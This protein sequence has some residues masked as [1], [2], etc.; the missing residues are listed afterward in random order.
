MKRITAEPGLAPKTI[1]VF[2]DASSSGKKR[3]THAGSLA[4]RWG[5]HLVGVNVVVGEVAL[6][7]SM[8]YA[9][10]SQA[11]RQVTAYK[12]RL[13]SDAAAATARVNEHFRALCA[14]LRVSGELRL[15]GQTNSVKEAVRIAFHS[16]LVVVGHPEPNGLS[17]DLSVEKLLLASGTPTLIVPNAWEGESIGTNVLIGWNA[18]REARRAVTDAMVFLVAAK[19][20]TV[21]VIDAHERYQTDKDRGSEIA[22]RLD[23]HGAHVDLERMVSRGFSIPAVLLGYA[24]Q[25]ASDLLVVGAYSRARFKELLLG[26]TTR[27]LLMHT[28][29]PTFMSR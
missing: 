27:T 29:M 7:A 13:A 1:A 26:G 15:I 9:R 5:A 12:R 22:L 10:G 18:T 23:R 8:S 11:L 25:S 3:A 19:S 28:S 14:E 2:L 16:D 4:Q 24:E 6:P 17:G 21:L 20:V